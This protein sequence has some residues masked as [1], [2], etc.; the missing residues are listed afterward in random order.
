M[1][2][3]NGV[4]VLVTGGAGF[5][6]SH[7]VDRLVAS[8]HEVVVLDNLTTG[9]R[10][11]VNPKAALAEVDVA[12]FGAIAPHFK[13]CK[14]VFHLAALA[15][16]QPSI[17]NPLPYNDANITGT[18]NV[19]WAAHKAGVKKVIYSA[20]SSAYGD[21][22]KFPLTEDMVARP[23]TPYSLQKYVGELYCQLFSKLYGLPT[24]CLRYFNVYGPRQILEGAY[25]AVI[26]IFLRQAGAGEPMTVVANGGQIRRD[27]THVSDVVE[28]NILAWQK[29][30]PGGEVI[31]IGTRKNYSIREV[32]AMVGGKTVD[33][34][35]RPG[36]ALVTLAD[37][38]KAAALLGWS[39]KVTFEEGVS[40]LKNETANF[41]F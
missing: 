14:A 39:P 40:R 27:F 24:V 2:I 18:L 35:P 29:D 10:E 1:R 31:N 4:K 34:P 5:I 12:D 15:R 38:S 23:K 25:A 41:N 17:E 16:I 22:Q 9:K 20:S 7:I 8:G 26:G 37:N 30:V 36:D 13:N 21:Q 11:N 32:A 3:S 33:I 28:A 19:L 6:G